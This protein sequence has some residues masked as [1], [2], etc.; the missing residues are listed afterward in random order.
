MIDFLSILFQFVGLY[1]ACLEAKQHSV[2]YGF[3]VGC[4]FWGVT[5]I[6][7]LAAKL[8]AEKAVKEAGK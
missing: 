5:V 3:W 7:V 2:M 6:W 8:G 4:G 1:V